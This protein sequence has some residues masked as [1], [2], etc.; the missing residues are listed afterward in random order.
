[1]TERVRFVTPIV[2]TFGIAACLDTPPLAEPEIEQSRV[3]MHELPASLVPKLDILIVVDDSVAMQPYHDRVQALSAMLANTVVSFADG[4]A[5]IRIAVTSNDGKLHR[6]P[7]TNSPYVTD[8]RDFDFTHH[9]NYIGRLDQTVATMVDVG[10]RGA[11]SQP[12]E[13][14]RHVLETN[15]QFLRDDAGFAVLMIGGTDDAS[16]LAV[17][18]Y[19]SWMKRLAGDSWHR[20][21]TIVGLYPESATRM[22]EYFRGLPTFIGLAKPI[23]YDGDLRQVMSQLVAAGRW[24]SWGSPCLEGTP[25]RLDPAIDDGRYDCAMSVELERGLVAVPQCESAATTPVLPTT[26]SDGPARAPTSA[27]WFLRPNPQDCTSESHL[28]FGLRGY[29]LSAHPALHLQCRSN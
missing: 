19:V 14:L 26:T 1:V 16:P 7:I 10:A 18:E 6:V 24:G 27:C 17:D 20:R 21:V 13:A 2:V 3:E 11:T 8:A 4:W 28:T 9:A 29:T 15:S 25:A 22:A 23:D 5:D 12:L